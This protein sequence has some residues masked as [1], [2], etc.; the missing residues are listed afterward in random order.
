ME[1]LSKRYAN[2]L[3]F[4]KDMELGSKPYVKDL[5]Q[6]NSIIFITKLREEV[7]KYKN[8]SDEDKINK[9]IRQSL[10]PYSLIIQA[11]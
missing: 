11:L 6:V 3:K 8:G 9:Q 7:D 2:F 5:E 1:I 10:Y 4:L